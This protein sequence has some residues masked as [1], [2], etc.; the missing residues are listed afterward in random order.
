MAAT[1]TELKKAKESLAQALSQP[2]SDIVR[3]AAIQR[4]EFC[5]ELAWKVLKKKMG[6]SSVAPKVIIREAAQQGLLAEPTLWIQFLDA[7]NL[8]SHTYNEDVAKEVFET[9]KAFLPEL[10]ALFSKLEKL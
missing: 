9:V 10:K 4:F 7:R 5:V 3:D 2:Y 1:I 8:S 6:S